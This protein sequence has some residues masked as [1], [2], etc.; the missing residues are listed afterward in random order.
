M[1]IDGVRDTEFNK[2]GIY[3]DS[4]RDIYLEAANIA[5]QAVYAFYFI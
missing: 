5:L 4:L 2:L 3:L 1:I